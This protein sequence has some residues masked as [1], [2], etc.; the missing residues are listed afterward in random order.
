M[1]RVTLTP[2][3]RYTRISIFFCPGS[4]RE[5]TLCESSFGASPARSLL[6]IIYCPEA[7]LSV[8]S[9]LLPPSS[10]HF[11]PKPSHGGDI[12]RAIKL[13][14]TCSFFAPVIIVTTTL[15]CAREEDVQFY[16]SPGDKGKAFP[17]NLKVWRIFC[18]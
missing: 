17:L 3:T 8:F 15:L 12:F 2:M 5:N 11:L 10:L 4:F 13:P 18:P 14:Q 6:T 9:F 16:V 1:Q 7:I